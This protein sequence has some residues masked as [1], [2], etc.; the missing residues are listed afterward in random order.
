LTDSYLYFSQN[1]PPLNY[2]IGSLQPISQFCIVVLSIV[3]ESALLHKIEKDPSAFAE[4]FHLYYKPIFGYIFRRIGD[5]D[6][7]ADIAIETFTKIF[8]HIRYFEYRGISIK[9]WI[10]RIASNEI[11]QFFR[12]KKKHNRLFERLEE[13]QD[14]RHYIDD[15]R[16]RLEVELHKHEQYLSVLEQVKTLPIKYQEVIALRYFEGKENKEIAEILNLNEGTL[17]SLLSR[18]LEKLREKCNPT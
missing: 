13:D 16:A 14:F 6:T 8:R 4:L 12:N 17:K 11:N 5:F 10:Y 9:V 18:G 1:F 2:K 7:A 3:T 15:D